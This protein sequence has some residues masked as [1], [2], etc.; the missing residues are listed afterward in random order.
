MRV[1]RQSEIILTLTMLT[2]SHARI[3]RLINQAGALSRAE[4]G[5]ELGVSKATMSALTTDLF[6][7]GML[8][9]NEIV[10]GAGRPSTKLGLEPASAFF[11]GISIA[12]NPF[13]A[14]VVNL[15]GEVVASDPISA[16]D[17][18]KV[19]AREVAK[20]VQ[21]R[22]G[23][24][25]GLRDRLGGLGIA[26][27]GLVDHETGV[28]VRSTVL[29]WRDVPIG[30]MVQEAVGL[31]TFIENDANAMALGEH[32]FG[33]LRGADLCSLI[34]VGD[35]VGCGH[36]INGQLHRG[37]HG[38]S[39]EI[40][41]ATIQINGTPCQCGK[42]GCLDTISSLRA[43]RIQAKAVGM[44]ENLWELDAAATRGE[45]P[46]I[47]VLHHAGVALGVAASH[48]IQILDAGKIVIAFAEGPEDG[49]FARVARQTLMSNV[50]NA[51]RADIAMVAMKSDL[52]AV[53]GAAVAASRSLFQM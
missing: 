26:V 38:G 40:A 11:I 52:G 21:R 44:P 35:G 10:Y 5:A 18:P 12:T 41:H 25:P 50:M 8:V 43:I 34:S 3:L 1:V 9:E 24:E 36:I 30:A 2:A 14:V 51:D 7:R 32:M 45:Q 47:G 13:T 31:P 16:S 42:R 28:C 6:E 46:A 33:S 19:I 15:H 53:G 17:D 4:L 29:G 49:L 27:P 23:K 37:A 20:V 39:G 48:I 22:L